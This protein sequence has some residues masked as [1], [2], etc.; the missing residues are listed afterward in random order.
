MSPDPVS[1]ED[2]AASD[3][4]NA[5]KEVARNRPLTRP[6]PGHADLVGHAEVR[7][8]RRPPG[9][10]A[11]LRPRDRGAGGPRRGG[12]AVPRAGLRHPAG[13]AHRRHRHGRRRRRRRRCR[14]PTRSTPSTPTRSA[15]ST[16]RA[17]P[18]WSPRSRR[19]SKDGD[20][21]G[22]VVEVRRLRAAARAWARTCTGTAGSTPSWPRALMGI[23]AI[24]GVEVGDGFRTAARRGSA[25]HDEMERGADGVDPP[26]HRPG[27]RHRGRHVDRR[28]AAGARRDEADLHRAAR[29]R[30]RRHHRC[31]GRPRRSTSAP[32][33]APCPPPASSPRRWSPSSSPRPASRSSAATRS[34][35]RRATTRH[36]SRRSPRRCARGDDA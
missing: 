22:G 25:A 29:P 32:T 11:R 15:P 34:P 23:Q 14:P 18:R 16:P 5:E 33:C 2:Y 35:R 17:R 31:R 12:G 13:V 21:L 20:T 28:R 10:R 30:H 4:V 19:P 1:A 24:K 6:R 36:T 3:D 26:P 8:R 27:R 9:A 7:L